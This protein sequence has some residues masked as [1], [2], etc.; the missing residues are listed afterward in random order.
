MEIL[1]LA[2]LA[3][4]AWLAWLGWRKRRREK[5]FKQPLPAEW[6]RILERNMPLYRRLPDELKTRLHGHIQLF[7]NDKSFYGFQGVVIDD[8]I[9]VTI[10][11]NACILLI[12]RPYPGY[13]NFSSVFVYPSTFM[14]EQESFDGVLASTEQQA[15]L[16]ESWQR[17]P[18]VLAWDSVLHG[19]RDIRDGHNVVLH[20]FAHK[21][22]DAD[23][24]VD[25]APILAQRSQFTSWARVMQREYEQLRRHAEA[26]TRTVL[27]HYGA[28]NPA[29]FFAV[30][31]ETFY[32]QPR[33][34]KE[35]HPELYRE[36]QTCFGVD[37]LAWLDAEL[38]AR[39]IS[40]QT[41]TS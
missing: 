36:M 1:I 13:A 15:R 27:D 22:D 33:Q 6:V 10:A 5:L 32:E 12:G 7:L 35:H 2:A 34:L 37:P 29:E 31:T 40:G 20:E 18:V 39:R 30:L 38:E 14:A 17:G 8:E 28:T 23:G 3:F 26:G 24:R 4:V 16:G 9:R 25:G 19:C 41:A 21:L 11:G